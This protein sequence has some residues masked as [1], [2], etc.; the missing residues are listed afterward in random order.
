MNEAAHAIFSFMIGGEAAAATVS[1]KTKF[2]IPLGAEILIRKIAR[3]RR[4]HA[5]EVS[6]YPLVS[7][8]FLGL[9]TAGGEVRG[10]SI[11]APSKARQRCQKNGAGKNRVVKKCRNPFHSQQLKKE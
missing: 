9:R 7:E 3:D 10:G 1:I 4:S 6:P 2:R 11:A 5:R 8:T